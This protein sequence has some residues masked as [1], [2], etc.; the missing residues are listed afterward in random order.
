[1][2]ALSLSPSQPFTSLH[3]CILQREKNMPFLSLSVLLSLSLSPPS[4]INSWERDAYLSL[5]WYKQL[6]ERK[7]CMFLSFSFPLLFKQIKKRDKHVYL[8]LSWYQE[9]RDRERETCM[10]SL[11]LSI[12][13]IIACLYLAERETCMFSFSLSHSPS[14]AFS[15]S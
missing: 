12:V 15:P 11:S 1:M 3:F 6:R 2:H 7:T 14:L 8:S 9:L 4:Y 13:Y 5:S 10:F